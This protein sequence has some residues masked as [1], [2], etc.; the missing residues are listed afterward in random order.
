ML[1]PV[2]TL[3]IVDAPDH[4]ASTCCWFRTG[5]EESAVCIVEAGTPSGSL[6]LSMA[7]STSFVGDINIRRL[8]WRSLRSTF[9]QPVTTE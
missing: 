4:R 2:A 9:L 1:L 5:W 6:E 8:A 7:S 3:Q